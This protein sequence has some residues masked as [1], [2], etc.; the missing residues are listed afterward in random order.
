MLVIFSNF[1]ISYLWPQRQK[2][3]FMDFLINHLDQNY[4][5][6]SEED[7]LKKI[8]IHLKNRNITSYEDFYQKYIKDDIQIL[9]NL[10][11]S[12][13]DGSYS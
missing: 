7:C 2:S 3:K 9:E 5:A 13:K 10:I 6:Q 11:Q 4:I 1:F 12:K 8:S